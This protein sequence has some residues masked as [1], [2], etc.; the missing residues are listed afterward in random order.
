[1]L[2]SR[3]NVYVTRLYGCIIP[4]L[5]LCYGHCA[6]YYSTNHNVPLLYDSRRQNLEQSRGP[7][8]EFGGCRAWKKAGCSSLNRDVFLLENISKALGKS[9]FL[10]VPIPAFFLKFVVLS[11]AGIR[12]QVRAVIGRAITWF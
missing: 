3:A 9:Q 11:C 5:R 1:M 7:R 8:S 4:H 10:K 12:S 2:G 6:F